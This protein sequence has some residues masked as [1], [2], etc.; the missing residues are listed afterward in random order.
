MV[1]GTDFAF[2]PATE[3]PNVQ[4][5]LDRITGRSAVAKVLKEK[6]ERRAEAER[7]AAEEKAKAEKS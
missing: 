4:A 7:K 3:Y 1:A 5:W 2:D 6:T